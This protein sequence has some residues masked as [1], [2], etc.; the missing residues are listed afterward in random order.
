VVKIAVACDNYHIVTLRLLSFFKHSDYFQNTWCE[1]FTYLRALK[2]Y[3]FFFKELLQLISSA[4]RLH[5]FVGLN[6]NIKKKSMFCKLF[7][8]GGSLKS[9][10]PLSRLTVTLKMSTTVCY[11]KSVS[12]RRVQTT[13]RQNYALYDVTSIICNFQ[14]MLL[15]LNLCRGLLVFDKPI[16]LK[17]GT[18]NVQ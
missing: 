7:K 10:F 8:L 4:C 18:T 9:F 13:E 11:E 17:T 5:E 1:F 16:F 2:I 12:I 6:Y 3:Y 14:S 15:C